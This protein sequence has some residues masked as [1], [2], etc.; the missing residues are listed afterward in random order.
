MLSVPGYLTN[1]DNGLKEAGTQKLSASENYEKT[2]IHVCACVCEYVYIFNIYAHVY[3]H[4]YMYLQHGCASPCPSRNSLCRPDCPLTHRNP[5]ASAC[6]V[7]GLDVCTTTLRKNI[8]LCRSSLQAPGLYIWF[9]FCSG[10]TCL[11]G[12]SL[13]YRLEQG[14]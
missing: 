8:D 12:K 10:L 3:V 13:L 11:K 1:R 7:L 6:L 9:C 2:L 5:L 4:M 14:I